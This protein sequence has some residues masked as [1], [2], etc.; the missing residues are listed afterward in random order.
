MRNCRI[1][2]P[3]LRWFAGSYAYSETTPESQLLSEIVGVN[4]FLE[5]D[6]VIELNQER[7]MDFQSY[8]GCSAI[9]EGLLR[10]LRTRQRDAE[11]DSVEG[12]AY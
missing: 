2:Q 10:T 8:A 7:S 3:Q 6:V 11:D 1:V 12:R 4:R 5:E 9:L